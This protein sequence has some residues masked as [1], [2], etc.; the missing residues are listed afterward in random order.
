[1][2][3]RNSESIKY[4]NNEVNESNLD[5]NIDEDLVEED[6]DEKY[7][8][9]SNQTIFYLLLLIILIAALM[10]IFKLY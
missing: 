2:E 7:K 6:D 4:V 5:E 1:M 9:D 10:Y 3:Q 8:N